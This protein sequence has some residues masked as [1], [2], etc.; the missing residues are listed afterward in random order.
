[1][2]DMVKQNQIPCALLPLLGR[3]ILVPN[4]ALAELIPWQEANRFN[5]NKLKW[6]IGHIHW[7]GIHL[8]IVSLELL[9]DPEIDFSTEG[10]R[11]AVIAT[12]SNEKDFFYGLI[13]KSPPRLINVTADELESAAYDSSAFTFEAKLTGERVFLVD[14]DNVERLVTTYARPLVNQLSN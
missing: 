3:S 14:L 11:I 1:M 5:A 10:R 12:R 8:P 6:L 4:R 7:R 2:T 9:H 13:L